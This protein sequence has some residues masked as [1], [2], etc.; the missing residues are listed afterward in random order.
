MQPNGAVVRYCWISALIAAAV[1]ALGLLA[2]GAGAWREVGLAVGLGWTV[3]AA[4][5]W[6]L[7]GL[8]FPGRVLVVYTV[9]LFGRFALVGVFALVLVP[10]LGFAPL[11]ALLSLVTVLMLTTVVEPLVLRDAAPSPA[12]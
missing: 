4:L 11:P 6:L 7:A 12:V 9:G 10:A 1:L 3:Q 2:A 5:V 8:L